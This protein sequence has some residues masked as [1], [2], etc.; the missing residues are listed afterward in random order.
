[1]SNLYYRGDNIFLYTQFTDQAGNPCPASDVKVR[2]L[3]DNNGTIMAYLNWKSMQQMSPTE[4]FYNYKIPNAANNGIYQIQYVGKVNGDNA[5]VVEAFHVI[6]RSDKYP[7]AIKI[8]GY[9]HDIR[10]T[11]ALID[12]KISIYDILTGQ[13]IYQSISNLDG[14]WEAYLYPGEYRF[15]FIREGYNIMDIVAQIGDEHTE[16]QFNN[17][18]L[19]NE[20]A[21]NKGNGMYPVSDRYVNKRSIPL[22]NLSINI[23][24]ANNPGGDPIARDTTDKDGNW[25][26]FL[27]PGTYLMKVDGK[28]QGSNFNKIFRIKVEN[29]GKFTFENLS[30]NVATAVPQTNIVPSTGSASL[31]DVVQDRNGNPIV[32]VQVNVFHTG[33]VLD[34]K[35]IIA[36]TYTDVHGKWELNL[37]PG[38]YVIEFYHP[39]FKAFTENKTVQ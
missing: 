23:F 38:T 3:H 20:L 18:G 31:S 25:Q 24:H 37:D 36:Q 11:V 27:D 35:N 12:S 32:D 5:C 28:A 10:T 17:V 26:C 29:D 21:S 34:D 15:S 16:I 4:Y 9:I 6:A 13:I 14:Y 22:S 33:V 19:E 30:K 1:M 7:N 8:Y 39:K 2:I